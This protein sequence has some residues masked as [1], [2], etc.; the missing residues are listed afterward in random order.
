MEQMK[1]E[2]LLPLNTQDIGKGGVFESPL[3]MNE[4][5]GLAGPSG[6]R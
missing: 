1:S 2:P 3:D 6:A 5:N 4:K